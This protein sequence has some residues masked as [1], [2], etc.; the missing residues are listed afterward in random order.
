[1]TDAEVWIT[2][3]GLRVWEANRSRSVEQYEI[4]RA[5]V[6][7]VQDDGWR[8]VAEANARIAAEKVKKGENIN[9]KTIG[10]ATARKLWNN[11]EGL[12]EKVSS[13]E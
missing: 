8:Y 9:M 3:L 12:K 4:L 10:K 2:D 6:K 5:A 7:D 13:K 11:G 1:M